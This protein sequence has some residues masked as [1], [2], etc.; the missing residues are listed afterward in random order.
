M[1]NNFLGWVRVGSAGNEFWTREAAG[2][3]HGFRMASRSRKLDG[4]DA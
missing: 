3:G 1:T 4:W 2:V